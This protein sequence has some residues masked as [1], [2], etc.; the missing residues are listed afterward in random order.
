[1]GPTRNRRRYVLRC[2]KH[3]GFHEPTPARGL[4]TYAENVRIEHPRRLAGGGWVRNY[5]L[6]PTQRDRLNA[7]L[8]F[9]T[10]T[11]DVG[12]F[13]PRRSLSLSLSLSFS[14]SKPA[15]LHCLVT[16]Q[17]ISALSHVQDCRPHILCRL[18]IRE[19]LS[20]EAHHAERPP[21]HLSTSFRNMQ[22]VR[23]QSVRSSR[24]RR[25]VAG[26]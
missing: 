24:P 1:M 26:L 23:I 6:F 25:R 14:H 22:I 18:L 9:E 15:C 17:W 4:K 11:R 13:R 21:S 20:H 16:P 8:A 10:R 19:K 2:G 7:R 12:T 3:F 5:T